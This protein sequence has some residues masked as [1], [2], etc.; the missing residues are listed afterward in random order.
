M[1]DPK[2]SITLGARDEA[3]PEVQKLKQ[4][5]ETLGKIKA[6]EKLKRDTAAAERQ[7]RAA[8]Q[9]VAAMARDMKAGGAATQKM[10][11][12]FE[13][14]KRQ[15]GA[16]KQAYIANRDG[17]QTMRQS[18][19]AAGVDTRRLGAAQKRLEQSTRE[20]QKVLAARGQ[21]KVAPYRE[22]RAEIGRLRSAYDTLKK[23]GTLSTAELIRAKRELRR[24]TAQL[25][26]E[27]GGWTAAIGKAHAALLGM[28]TAGYAF[29]QS[30]RNYSEFR[31]RMAEIDTIADTSAERMGQLSEEIRKLA[32]RIPQTASEL[33]AAEYDILSAG[34][35]LEKS[36][37]TL[38]LSSRAA[39]AGLTTTKTAANAG[40]GVINAYGKSIDDL[41]E[42]YD[43]LFQTVKSGVTT[44]PQLAKNI[45]EVLP[46][47][48]AADVE[49]Q[50]VAAAIAAMTKAGIRTPQ[51]TTALK[52]AINALA[53]PAPEARKQFEAL[54]ITWQGLI[55]TLDQ[56]RKKGLSIDQ[57][58]LLIPDVEAR[59][60]VLALTQNF[61]QLEEI[62]GKMDGAAG[63]MEE[64][65]DKMKDTPENQIKLLKNEFT[66]LLF[67]A[68]A[69][70]AEG[71]IPLF[72]AMRWVMDGMREMDT[73]TKIFIA[74]LLTAGVAFKLW[75]MG[76]GDI[77]L[78]L[79]K[80]RH[81]M[82]TAGAAATA[83]SNQ[84][85]AAGIGMKAAFAGVVVF[86]GIQLARLG[87]AMYQAYKAGKRAEASAER[88]A[89]ANDKAVNS[90]ASWKDVQVPDDITGKAPE[91]LEALKWEL[92][93][94]KLYYQQLVGQMNR[95]D[96][97]AG[98]EEAKKR[99]SEVRRGLEKVRDA[100]ADAAD[101][102]D[103]PAE[104]VKAT[105]DQLDEFEKKAKDA[106]EKAKAE[107]EKY[108][109]EIEKINRRIADRESD[110][111]DKIR[112]FKRANLSEEEQAA[113]IRLQAIE[114]IQAANAA[115]ARY[116]A[117]DSEAA[118]DDAKRFFDD[119]ARLWERY[120]GQGE[121][122][123]TEAIQGLEQ[124]KT[125][126]DA[127]DQAEI[128]WIERMRKQAEEMAA[129]IEQQ[130]E[131]LTRDREANIDIVLRRLQDAQ[132]AINDLT[133]DETK[134]IYVTVHQRTV[135]EH[136]GGGMAGFRRRSGKLPGFGGGDRIR[137][138]LEAGEYIIRKEAV[139]KY[140]AGLFHA[141]N[142]M[143]LALPDVAGMVRAQLGGL[144]AGIPVPAMASGGIAG[145]TETMILDL[146]AGGVSA[147]LRVVGSPAATRQAVKTIEKELDRM[148]LSHR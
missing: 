116:Q 80:L 22:V 79:G 98:L 35:S 117:E 112:E 36:T 95:T 146:R 65:Y 70:A 21:L 119:A 12:E 122:A 17:L 124:I 136:A 3:S 32:L 139:Q 58:R 84:W 15:A 20:A 93:R 121:E 82:R 71:L 104:A 63:A 118:R 94:A 40:I 64:A 29:I 49:F 74:T 56:I 123:T 133:R 89:A 75:K 142:G 91:E 78:G 46:T 105:A 28:A 113:D 61:E 132:A 67:S 6:F 111:E 43:L 106:Y 127:L 62:L 26:A 11:R 92:F 109:A 83:M 23:S 47:A 27:T 45:G 48:R 115:L 134:H 60:G 107:A 76:L 54:G 10:A 143:R 59:T 99:L 120:A 31:Q 1:T 85:K 102:M 103:K 97:Q 77:V 138:L 135:E 66:D 39:V 87:T 141:L 50:D 25:K 81:P 53:A 41:D 96:N 126:L 55:P 9:Q 42:V 38:E 137:S 24:Q 125:G 130:L 88:A 147:P 2:L 100:A 30:F 7:W 128:G 33:A 37:R 86:T 144:V 51:A 114:K 8:Q 4:E 73:P 52:G 90:L 72:K 57:M 68:S 69:L 110:T 108:A 101:E 13:Q 148:R 145:P 14:A 129:G 19:V 34:V 18:L 16:L 140:G 44:F 131:Q 5:L